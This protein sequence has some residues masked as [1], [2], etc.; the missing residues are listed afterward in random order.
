MRLNVPFYKQT[1][2]LNCGPAALKMA[3]SYLGKD[4]DMPTL[5]EKVGI[6]EGRAVS[7][8]RLATASQDLG[9]KT[10]FYSKS[11]LFDPKHLEK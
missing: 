4:Y 11:L 9:Y 2:K 10:E 5:E 7:T 6:M 1:T 3:L 8:I